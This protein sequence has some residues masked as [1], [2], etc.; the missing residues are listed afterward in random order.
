MCLTREWH[1][2]RCQPSGS[3]E[4]MS[5]QFYSVGNVSFEM[6]SRLDVYLMSAC[7]R[8]TSFQVVYQHG[9]DNAAFQGIK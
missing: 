9:G 5:K 1:S 2:C 8:R 6:A 3:Y 7:C 4:G